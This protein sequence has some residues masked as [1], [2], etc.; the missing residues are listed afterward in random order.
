MRRT[1]P[2]VAAVLL[3]LGTACDGDDT[4]TAPD[5]S[6]LTSTTGGLGDGDGAGDTEDAGFLLLSPAFDE[7]ETIPERFARDGE[8][9]SPPLVW[10]FPPEDHVEYV[11]V[12][13]DEDAPGDPFVHWMVAGIPAAELTLTEGSVPDAAVEGEN[14][15]G[16]T[17]WDGPAPPEGE[18]HTY[19]FTVHA[20]GDPTDL[21]EGFTRSELEDVL[22]GRVIASAVLTARYPGDD[23]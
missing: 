20:L 14:D 17:G 6:I 11:V 2:A 1:L 7:G 8:N 5:E 13:E 10:R 23:S 15:F 22:E 19:R 21:D 9:V 3:L 18:T 16:R 4:G 12:V